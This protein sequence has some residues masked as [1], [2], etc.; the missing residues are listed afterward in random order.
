MAHNFV[1]LK[2]R[3][4]SEFNKAAFNARETEFI[5]PEKAAVIANTTL[6]GPGETVEVTFK[7]PAKAG[8]YPSL[9]IPRPLRARHAG[10]AGRQV[11]PPAS[12]VMGAPRRR[13]RWPRRSAG[14]S[15][16]R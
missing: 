6:A 10:H 1:L 13:P 11:G 3:D 15:A 12:N 8:S 14:S 9:L 7:V 5:P 2:L 16:V 4:L